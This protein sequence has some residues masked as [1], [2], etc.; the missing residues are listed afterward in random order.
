MPMG[1]VKTSDLANVVRNGSIGQHTVTA[2]CTRD[3]MLFG[4][5]CELLCEL[6]VV[7]GA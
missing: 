2:A 4:A 5:L 6:C 3:S 1:G 7:L